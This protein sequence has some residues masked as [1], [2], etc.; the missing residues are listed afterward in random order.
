M[1]VCLC[2]APHPPRALAHL[3]PSSAYIPRP[4]FPTPPRSLTGLLGADFGLPALRA[5]LE[6]HMWECMQPKARP[7]PGA[8]AAVSSAEA[9]VANSA[10]ENGSAQDA[11]PAAPQS[12]DALLQSLL[13]VRP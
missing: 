1:E 6:A 2:A 9:A 12:D 7:T 13:S 10:A 5:T 11:A 4:P 3:G 8:G